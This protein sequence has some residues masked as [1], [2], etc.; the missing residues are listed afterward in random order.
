MPAP[1]EFGD[2]EYPWERPLGARP[3]GDVTVEFRVW[4]PRAQSILLRVGGRDVALESAGYGVYETIAPARAGEDYVYVLDGRPLPDPASRS[5]PPGI[6]GPSRIVDTS[7]P[8]AFP[9]PRM[10]ELAIYE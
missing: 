9:I 1:V 10:R 8:A 7:A 3:R 2:A 6:R 5:Q 4:A